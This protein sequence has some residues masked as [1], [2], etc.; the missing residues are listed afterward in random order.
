FVDK[1][2]AVDR[3]MVDVDAAPETRSDMR[4]AHR[5]VDQ[6]VRD[7]IAERGFCPAWVE[8]LERRWVHAILQILRKDSGQDR[9]PGN[10]HLPAD[11]LAGRIEPAVQFAL[12]DRVIIAM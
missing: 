1:A 9:L 8:P 6:H 4:V 3:V 5:M 12:R 11:E 2:F 7:V 10:A